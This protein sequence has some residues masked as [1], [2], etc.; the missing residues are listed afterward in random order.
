MTHCKL[1][2]N[3]S[4]HLG[5]TVPWWF[6]FNRAF[7]TINPCL[8]SGIF[9]ERIYRRMSTSQFMFIPPDVQK[10]L[11]VSN[12]IRIENPFIS[13][14]KLGFRF[15]FLKS[16]ISSYSADIFRE[17]ERLKR[18]RKRDIESS[19]RNMA[20][21]WTGLKRERELILWAIPEMFAK[22]SLA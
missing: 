1:W 11:N 5:P 16:R 13:Q 19:F 3:G 21:D 8:I 20:E 9:I 17:R 18:E 14:K 12:S 10:Y 15:G 7:H 2:Q 6:R 4:L 22:L